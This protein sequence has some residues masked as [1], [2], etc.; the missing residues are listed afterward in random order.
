MLNEDLRR[1]WH[2]CVGLLIGSGMSF[3][4]GRTSW[5]IVLLIAAFAVF[6]AIMIWGGDEDE[7]AEEA[8]E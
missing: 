7:E 6:A 2:I 8:R 5:G 3:V 1:L 4:T